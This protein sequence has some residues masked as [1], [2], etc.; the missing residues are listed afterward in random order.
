VI[1]GTSAVD[2]P[3]SRKRSVP[4]RLVLALGLLAPVVLVP[5]LWPPVSRWFSAE[6]T[7][8]AARLRIAEVVRGDLERD[9]SV[10]GQVVAAFHPT[11]SSPARGIVR[12]QVRAGDVVERGAVLALVESPELESRVQQE[13][14][15]LQSL[16]SGQERARVEARQAALADRHQVDLATVSLEAAQRARSRAERSRQEGILNQVDYET[17]QDA[18]SRATIELAHARERA[19]L[20]RDTRE[21][22]ARSAQLAI[23]RQRLVVHEL[24]RQVADL[25]VRAP[26][27]GLVSRLAVNDHDA[28]EPGAPLVTVVDL[29]AFEI[30]VGIPESYAVEIGPGTPAVVTYD[31][32]EWPA[33]VK[34]IAPEVR[35]SE[36]RGVVAFVGQEPAGLRQ[37]QRLAT[38]VILESRTGVLKVARGPF[39]ETGGG[40]E[41][42]VIRG[43]LAE[44]S[45]IAVGATSVTEVEIVSGLAAGDRIIVSDTSSFADARRV[46]LRR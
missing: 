40:R 17:A 46:W 10:Q 21:F 26:V 9:V 43:D 36:V 22:E 6:R 15:G 20:A 41:A 1:Q 30:E 37:N 5:L 13:R 24:E 42:W 39:V 44:R 34:I 12:L 32:R 8:D 3:V 29:S 38:R 31:G 45:P 2:R 18:L 23:E 25:S 19:D 11:V 14:S 4:R 33:A 7:I 35:G 28:V 27:G 16:E